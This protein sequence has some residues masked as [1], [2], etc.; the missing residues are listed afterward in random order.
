V[1][2]VTLPSIHEGGALVGK[3]NV[4]LMRANEETGILE[5]RAAKHE[6]PHEIY[7]GCTHSGE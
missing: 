3:T 4:E 7:E 5:D 1:Q 6:K 2:T